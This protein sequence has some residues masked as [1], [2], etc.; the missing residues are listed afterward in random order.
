M[1]SRTKWK[2][3]TAKYGGRVSLL[4]LMTYDVQAQLRRFPGLLRETPSDLVAV[5]HRLLIFA[6]HSLS[7][8]SELLQSVKLLWDEG[9]HLAA[10]H[11]VRLLFEIWG[12][13]LYAQTSV[14]EKA[15][16]SSESAVIADARL[17]KLL[18]GTNSRPLLPAGIKEEI[19]VI[20]VMEFVRAGETAVQEFTTIYKFLCDIS[21]P[22]YM[23]NFFCWLTL[24]MSWSNDLRAREIHR[25]LEE[26][27]N[28]AEM[29]T[30]NISAMVVNIYNE[31]MPDLE[32]EIASYDPKAE[33]S[34]D[35]GA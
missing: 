2:A 33:K 21:H 8:A 14:L 34:D 18:L 28:A 25:I 32:K 23:H 22:T 12:S 26:M 16:E 31:C 13:L 5:K 29:A 24:D 27:I 10:G 4:T 9:H 1:F 3:E 7:S 15:K 11:C 30:K 35:T 6:N 20:N 17:Q 19:G